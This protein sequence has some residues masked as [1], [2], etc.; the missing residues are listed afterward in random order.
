MKVNLHHQIHYTECLAGKYAAGVGFQQCDVCITG[1]YQPLSGSKSCLLCPA[2]T[3]SLPG[4]LT[5]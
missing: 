5:N 3:Y 2:G 4:N 1:S